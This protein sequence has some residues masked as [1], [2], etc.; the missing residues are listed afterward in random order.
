MPASC[1][2]AAERIRGLPDWVACQMRTA[3]GLRGLDVSE[4]P[5]DCCQAS[6][7]LDSEAGFRLEDV[8]DAGA[9]DVSV[10]SRAD[11]PLPTIHALSSSHEIA[12]RYFAT[13]AMSFSL[14]SEI[15]PRSQLS[16]RSAS[17]TR[18]P[19]GFSPARRTKSS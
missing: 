15:R 1:Q 11:L 4:H 6:P 14:G 17:F 13:R 10:S 8:E 5:A 18:R 9:L 16:S 3:L 2:P 7:A 19:I 12:H